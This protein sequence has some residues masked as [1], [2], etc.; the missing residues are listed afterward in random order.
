MLRRRGQAAPGSGGT[1]VLAMRRLQERAGNRAVTE[2]VRAG[3]LHR[4]V[5]TATPAVQRV[6]VI[7][8]VDYTASKHAMERIAQRGIS[9]TQLQQTLDN[10]TATFKEGNRKI[11]VSIWGDRSKAIKAVMSSDTPMVL[12]TVIKT[13]RKGTINKWESGG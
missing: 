13:N 4:L 2:A 3:T 8:R 7:Q 11:F 10:P 9:P 6:P 5:P 12:I 1:L